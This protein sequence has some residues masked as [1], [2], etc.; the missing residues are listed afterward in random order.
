MCIEY[1]KIYVNM[2]HVKA[3]GFDERMINVHSP[4]SPS[5]SS[6]SSLKFHSKRVETVYCFLFFF[7]KVSF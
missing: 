6:S 1:C 2:Y 5:S 7:A 4:S 3:Q